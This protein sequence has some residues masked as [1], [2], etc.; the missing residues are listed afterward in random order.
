MPVFSCTAGQGE[1]RKFSSKITFNYTYW[2]WLTSAT[3]DSYWLF[4][5]CTK[6]N[7]ALAKAEGHYAHA[8]MLPPF[9]QPCFSLVHSWGKQSK[10]RRSGLTSK[11]NAQANMNS[12]SPSTP[13][14]YIQQ[15]KHPCLPISPTPSPP[16]SQACTPL[17]LT[18]LLLQQACTEWNK[19]SSATMQL[20]TA[21]AGSWQR[22]SGVIVSSKL[23]F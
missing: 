22:P 3:S 8:W 13:K 15:H 7:I 5:T 17:T 1:K 21:C 23:I 11:K 12:F 6:I 4:L 19:V 10:Q 2:P 18:P 20:K 9:W 16:N 14:K